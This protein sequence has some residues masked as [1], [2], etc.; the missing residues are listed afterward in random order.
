MIRCAL[1]AA[2]KDADAAKMIGFAAMMPLPML[3]RAPP[4][5]L[6]FAALQRMREVQKDVDARRQQ[7]RFM[8]RASCQECC[9]A[10]ALARVDDVLPRRAIR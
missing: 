9:G 5:R 1:Y 10:A 7:R 3:P 8:L 2:L 4:L 6:R